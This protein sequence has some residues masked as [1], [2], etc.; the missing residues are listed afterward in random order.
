MRKTTLNTIFIKTG[1]NWIRDLKSER[2]RTNI[3]I[4]I[5]QENQHIFAN[6][7]N[8]QSGEWGQRYGWLDIKHSWLVLHGVTCTSEQL[9]D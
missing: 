9:D 3:M 6:N 7:N 2:G 5:F 8:T 1:E 4:K